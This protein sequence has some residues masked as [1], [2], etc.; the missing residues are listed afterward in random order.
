MAR[1]SLVPLGG[2]GRF[3]VGGAGEKGSTKEVQTSTG[4]QEDELSMLRARNKELEEE[5]AR[6]SKRWEE[7]RE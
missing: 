4:G 1:A 7:R 5:V 6:L 2:S 3:G